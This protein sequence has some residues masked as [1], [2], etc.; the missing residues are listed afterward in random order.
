MKKSLTISSFLFLLAFIA[1]AQDKLEFKGQASAWINF[2][3]NNELELWGGARYLPQLNL[4]FGEESKSLLDFEASANLNGTLG[5]HPF[6]TLYSSGKLKPYRLWARYSTEQWEIRAGLQ[7][8]NFGSATTIRPLMWFDKLDPRDPLQLTDGVWGVLGR[9]YFLNNANLWLWVL[10]GNK[11]PKT[12]EVGE[13]SHDQ[14]E[15]GGRFQMQVPKGEMGLSFH[16]RLSDTRSLGAK[17]TFNGLVPENRI[18]IDGKYDLGI[19]LWFEGVWMNKSKNIG[20]YTNQLMASIGADY[21]FGVGNGLNVVFEQLLF[22]Y[23]EK[24]FQIKDPFVFSTL[25]MN[26][27]LGMSDNLSAMIYYDWIYNGLYNIINWNHQFG[28]F[29]FYCMGYSNPKIYKIPLTANDINLFAGTGV[30]LMVVWNH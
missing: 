21:T 15:F 4:K 10:Y 27:S 23:G 29:T 11:N 3:P 8:I 22:S 13:T 20:Q 17:A 7:K 24:P 14:P 19:G 26:Y 30:Q 5:T 2:N 9:Y 25:S 1:H 12:W 18:G 6:D 16:H 28:N